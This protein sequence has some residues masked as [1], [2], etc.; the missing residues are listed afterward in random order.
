MSIEDTVNGRTGHICR[1]VF[2]GK[3]SQISLKIGD[4][5]FLVYQPVVDAKTKKI[6]GAE[7]LSRLNSSS[8]GVLNPAS[9]LSAVDSVGLNNKF[10]YYIFEKNCKWISNDKKQR[11]GYKYTIIR[12]I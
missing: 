11:E 12:F 9:F 3:S 10:D 5:F 1:A 4:R 2:K 6:I 8:D 7:A